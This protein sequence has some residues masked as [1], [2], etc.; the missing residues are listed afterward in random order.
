MPEA[1]IPEGSWPAVHTWP[2][3]IWLA[4]EERLR[5]RPHDC[6]GPSCHPYPAFGDDPARWGLSYPPPMTEAE[7]QAADREY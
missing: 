7:I 3:E 5:D 2:A 1:R 4:A 6:P